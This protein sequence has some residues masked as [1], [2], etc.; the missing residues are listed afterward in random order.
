MARL[1]CNGPNF[2]DSTFCSDIS[3]CGSHLGFTDVAIW[4]KIC[5]TCR[6]EF[7]PVEMS[8]SEKEGRQQCE[9][10]QFPLAL[11]WASSDQIFLEWTLGVHFEVLAGHPTTKK[12]QLSMMDSPMIEFNLYLVL[13]FFFSLLG[14]LGVANLPSCLD[15]YWLRFQG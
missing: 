8:F 1:S 14:C 4:Y 5:T 6:T 11:F 7:L 3:I 13:S 9:G 2:L 15:I 10:F 12:D